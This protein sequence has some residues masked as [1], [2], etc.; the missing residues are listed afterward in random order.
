MAATEGAPQRQLRRVAGKSLWQQLRE[1]LLRRVADGEFVDAF[2]GEWELRAEYGV[3]RH[4]VREALRALREEGVVTAERGRRPRVAGQTEITQPL[5]A[6]YSLFESVES[7]HLVQRS[8]VRRLDRRQD[9]H[10]AVHLGLEESTPLI[11]LERLRLADDRPL[12]L[13]CT[14]LPAS[15]AEPLLDVDFTHTSLYEE[16]A[17]RCDVRLTGGHENIRAIIP[18]TAHRRLLDLDPN[19]AVMCVERTGHLDG[20][21][22]EWRITAI[23]GD[24]FSVLADFSARTGYTTQIAVATTSP[25]A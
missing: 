18:T 21:P 17:T 7:Q 12:A 15:I 10:A 14:W 9:A 5:G 2:P 1:D 20:N 3:S 13:D 22:V 25:A 23:R 6:L 24:R 11:Y 19:T 4:T 8:I 16:L